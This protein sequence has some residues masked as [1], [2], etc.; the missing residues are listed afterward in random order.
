MTQ[1]THSSDS[2]CEYK[3]DTSIFL[4]GIADAAKAC[5]HAPKLT[6]VTDNKTKQSAQSISSNAATA[7]ASAKGQGRLK[8]KARTD[9]KK[10][11]EVKKA[12]GRTKPEQEEA[13][14]QKD[15]VVTYKVAVTEILGQ[16]ESIVKAKQRN[17]LSISAERA[18][19]R[20]IA[21]RE[22]FAAAF[23]DSDDQ[24]SNQGHQHF[25][26]VL[27]Q[28]Y[29]SLVDA[30]CF[31][32]QNVTFNNT[33]RDIPTLSNKFEH[34]ELEEPH[35]E[36]QEPL[37]TKA[38]ARKQTKPKTRLIEPDVDERD[39]LV[40]KFFCY[41]QDLHKLQD[42]TRK[43]L[44]RYREGELDDLTHLVVIT[45]AIEHARQQEQALI[46]DA[47]DHLRF[48]VRRPELI[49]KLLQ[50]KG[51]R[52]ELGSG[53]DSE[54]FPRKRDLL[55]RQTRSTLS[56]IAAAAARKKDGFYFLVVPQLTAGDGVDPDLTLSKDWMDEHT[57][58]VQYLNELVLD[59]V[60][61]CFSSYP[62]IF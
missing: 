18:A 29:R 32:A 3:T 23:H 20:P 48:V 55:F 30:G 13:G 15:L 8:G 41:L 43:V 26:T 54:P 62:R 21:V 56:R 52:L 42:F 25:I 2:Y 59:E 60:S 24:V 44:L 47:P 7:T 6:L 46:E 49:F 9:A 39:E 61:I 36:G 17:L 37:A 10:L 5:G 31:E 38:A 40:F 1:R 14:R 22:Q 50:K 12:T 34:L 33:K 16:V 4:S 19:R 28:A 45:T 58:L 53:A 51:V 11:E 27:K 57:F 35:E